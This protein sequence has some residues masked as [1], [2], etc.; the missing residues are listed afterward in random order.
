MTQSVN[1]GTSPIELV[2][3]D[4]T[5]ETTD[6]IVNAANAELAGGGGVDGAIHRAGGPE[7]MA[8]C[9]AI[10]SCPTGRAVVTTAGALPAGKIIHAVAPRYKDGT[11]GEAAQLASAYNAA[12]EIASQEGLK[13]IAFPSLGT[14]AHGY[15]VKGAAR[16]ALGTVIDFL[17]SHPQV[18]RVRFV[19][20]DDETL[21]A[22]QQIL[23]E[24]A[25]TR[26]PGRR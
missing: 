14:G 13:T 18:E 3:G 23:M 19:L 25:P 22:Y 26:R 12:L 11:H 20:Y 1:I 4:L 9:R 10:G 7:I 16:I 21:E 6:G 5:H 24:E 2:Q 17:G 15:P 8:A